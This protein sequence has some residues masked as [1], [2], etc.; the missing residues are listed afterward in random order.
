MSYTLVLDPLAHVEVVAEGDGCD[1][2]KRDCAP[3]YVFSVEGQVQ[4]REALQHLSQCRR[5]QC[6]DLKSEVSDGM[7]TK[8]VWLF[9]EK[10]LLGCV[11][12]QPYLYGARRPVFSRQTFGPMAHHLARCPKESCAQLRR[13]LML[14]VRDHLRPN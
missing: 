7:K 8:V 13:A 9:N 10:V 11:Q 5:R 12:V 3:A 14:S 2:V 6:V 1:Q 4:F